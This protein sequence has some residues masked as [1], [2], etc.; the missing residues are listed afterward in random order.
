M[1]RTAKKREW[2]QKILCGWEVRGRATESERERGGEKQSINERANVYVC[3][4]MYIVQYMY[5]AWI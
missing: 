5:S 3:V 1:A 2:K 4:F